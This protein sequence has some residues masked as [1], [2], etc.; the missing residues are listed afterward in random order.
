MKFPKT[1][2]VNWAGR[3]NEEYLDTTTK[4]EFIDEGVKEVAIYELREIKNLKV[5]RE[6]K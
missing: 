2:Y 6:L 5:T 3:N 4:I 1:L